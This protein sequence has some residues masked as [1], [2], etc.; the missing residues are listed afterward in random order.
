MTRP[1]PPASPAPLPPPVP[2][3]SRPVPSASPLRARLALALGLGLGLVAPRTAVAWDPAT[4]HI[5]MVDRAVLESAL[6]L[7]WMAG[8]ELQ[9]GLFSPLRVDPA[10]LSPGERRF[11][12]AALK[13]A[14]SGAGVL[15]L[16]GPGAC[17]G[18][19]APPATQLFC[20]DGDLWEMPA[21]HWLQFGVIAELVPS[22]RA[23]HHFVD[24][25]D[26]QSPR[27]ADPQL[28]PLLLRSR[29][30]RH[31]G[32]PLAGYITG[33][34]F[35]GTGP[36]AIAWL[37][38]GADPLAPPRTFAHLELASTH[39]DPRARD[40]HLAMALIGLG[41]LLHVLQDM[42]VPA[43]AR[44]DVTAFFTPL[45]DVPGDRG[46]LFTELARLSFGRHA[47]PGRQAA[48]AIAEGRG[49]A[50]AS[51]LRQHFL[52]DAT[53]EGLAVFTGRRFLSEHSVPAP[54]FLEPEQSPAEA[55]ALLLAEADLDPL[56]ITGATLSPWP[57]TRGYIK[58]V[59]GRP[60]AA[61]D[62]DD[63]GRVRTFIDEAVYREQ[64][65]QLAPRAVAATRSLIDWM[66]PSWPEL[67]YDA[68]AGTLDL[69]VAADLKDPELLVFTQTAEGERTITAKVRLRPGIRNRV[70]ALP[71]LQEDQRSVVVLR[72][73]RSSGE[74]LIL[75]QVLGAASKTF[76]VVPPPYVAPVRPPPLPEAESESEPEPDASVIAPV[77]AETTLAP[78]P[79]AAEPLSPLTRPKRRL[80]SPQPTE[81]APPAS[82]PAAA[83][84]KP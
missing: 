32:A 36:S 18:P 71:K 28:H 82:E 68:G 52:G 84:P 21:L 80:M 60:L 26:P 57:A 40:H 24:R 33:S 31:N 11:L 81:P 39:P 42:S 49:V 46:L 61:F 45:S 25:D 41:A 34:S 62:T 43:H 16:G 72:A 30:F 69:A 50:L 44:G 12:G 79:S 23:V 29:Q 3:A 83:P 17:P 20:V 55:A 67:V 22:A 27:F 13:Q 77:E 66:W 15:P 14:P 2:S 48:E 63:L 47:L 73:R 65:S 70:S 35:A 1:V 8:S 4:T 37:D 54:R 75:E 59:T 53:Y 74:P 58:T 19:K 51:G 64:F 76:P 56:E 5:G 6:H 10:R 9:R 38:D 78:E 7:R